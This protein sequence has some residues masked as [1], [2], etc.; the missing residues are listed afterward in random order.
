MVS[1]KLCKLF[2]QVVDEKELIVES[3]ETQDSETENYQ[4]LPKATMMHLASKLALSPPLSSNISG[5]PLQM[6]REL[7][8]FKVILYVPFTCDFKVLSDCFSIVLECVCWDL[9]IM[10]NIFFLVVWQNSKRVF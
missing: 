5:T 8:W 4:I 2:A 6:Q 3:T 1:E 10:Q 9:F 7:L